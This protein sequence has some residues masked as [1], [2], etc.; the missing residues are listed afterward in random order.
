[1]LELR[2][3]NVFYG[4]AQALWD[5]DLDVA[6]GEIVCIVGPN[7][8]GKSTLVQAIA[9]LLPVRT[10]RVVVDGTDVSRHPAHRVC[11]S[12]VAIVPEGRRIF[13]GMTVSDNLDLG[14]YRSDAR[15]RVGETR[16][17][18]L[19]LFPRL[20][21]RSAQL[22]GTLSGGEQQMLAIGRALM[23][24]P[25]VLLLDEPSLGLAPVIVDEVFDVIG[26][27]N[28]SGVAVV[29]VEQNVQRAL[30][31]ATRAYLLSEGRVRMA[32]TAAEF[33]GNAEL[34]RTVLGIAADA[35]L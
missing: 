14:A 3:L 13:P 11:E 30:A 34:Q 8:A 26:Q 10:G 12:G 15:R 25:R 5:V 23:A 4:D 2:G 28:G 35:A 21:E 17:W 1:M 33:I 20:E 22:A 24:C 16:R 19:D 29:L 27:I 18:V 9:G 32:G 7:G 6:A 31:L